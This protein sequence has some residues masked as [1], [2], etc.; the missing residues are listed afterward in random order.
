M[1][2]QQVPLDPPPTSPLPASPTIIESFLDALDL[3]QVTIVANDSGGAMSQILVT[4]H[5]RADRRG[6]S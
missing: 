3:N 1:G 2:A 5:P 6:W 4:R